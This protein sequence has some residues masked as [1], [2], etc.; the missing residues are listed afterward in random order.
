[1]GLS[2]D[3]SLTLAALE[4]IDQICQTFEL[5]WQ[6]GQAPRIEAYLGDVR[7]SERLSL[8]YQLLLLEL[9]Y[10]S[11]HGDMPSLEH[12]RTRFSDHSALIDT[13]FDKQFVL[14]TNSAKASELEEQHVHEK[15]A[16]ADN[17]DNRASPDSGL[18][19]RCPHCHKKTE[20][21]VNT[22]LAEITCSSCGCPFSLV[23][24]STGS[25]EPK[26]LKAL[27]HFLLVKQL[28]T[29]A[30][31]S[32]WKAHDTKLDRDVAV[33][34]PRRD[35]LSLVEKEQ[36]LREAR[37]VAQLNHPQIV[38]VHELGSE[39]GQL[40]IVSDFVEGVS[41]AEWI[42]DQRMTTR[43]AAELCAKVAD[44]LEHAHQ[45]GV[46][47]RDLKPANIMLDAEGEPHI[48]DF[49]LA[50][51]E[52]GEVT[53]TVEGKMLGT[54]AYMSP[55]QAKG[56]AHAADCR[57]DVYSLGVILFE[58]LSGERPFRGNTRML[59]HQVA[60]DEPPSPRKL[61]SIVPRDL[62]TICLKCLEKDSARRYATGQE[63]AAELKRFLRGEPIHARPIR[64]SERM[65]RWCKRKPLVAGLAALVALLLLILS[66]GGPVVAIHR[67]ALQREANDERQNALT[68]RQLVRQERDTALHNLYISKMRQAYLD[69]KGGLGRR[70]QNNLLDQIPL[71]GKRDFRSW[72]WYF[73]LSQLY[74]CP[75]TIPIHQEDLKR[76]TPVTNLRYRNPFAWSPDGRRL[77]LA[78]GN[79][80][81]KVWDASTESIEYIPRGHDG[82][83]LSVDWKPDGHQLASA[84]EDGTVRIWDSGTYQVLSTLRGHT[85]AVEVVQ[86]SPDGT[87]L[88]SAGRDLT[89]RIWDPSTGETVQ[90]LK[91]S[92]F[93]LAWS[94]DGDRLAVGGGL[95]QGLKKSDYPVPT[96]VNIWEAVTGELLHN[97]QRESPIYAVAWSPDG[98]K[99]AFCG[100]GDDAGS[101][102]LVNAHT[103]EMIR[104]MNKNEV[105]SIAWGPYGKLLATASWNKELGIWDVAS[106]QLLQA[107]KGHKGAVVRV[108][109]DPTESRIATA[110]YD[111]TVKIWNVDTKTPLQTL[112]GH[113]SSVISLQWNWNGT[114]LASASP[115][116]IRVWEMKSVP[117]ATQSLE[118]NA[119]SI[120]PFAISPNVHHVITTNNDQSLSVWAVE[121]GKQIHTI[122]MKGHAGLEKLSAN[123]RPR[124]SELVRWN[125]DTLEIAW[126]DREAAVHIWNTTTDEP[127]RSLIGHTSRLRQLAWSQDGRRL[128]SGDYEC[129]VRIWDGPSGREEHVIRVNDNPDTQVYGVESLAWSNHGRMLASGTRDGRVKIWDTST[130]EKLRSLEGHSP[131]Q[132]IW[133]VAWSPDDKRLASG[134]WDSIVRIWDVES[135]SELWSLQG[136]IAQIGSLAWTA[137]GKRLASE[138]ADETVRIWDV[139]LGREIMVLPVTS[140]CNLTFGA[141]GTRL[142]AITGLSERH[143]W[144]ASIGYLIESQADESWQ[145]AKVRHF[146][147]KYVRLKRTQQLTEAELAL[148]VALT[149]QEK[150]IVAHPN[151]PEFQ[152]KLNQLHGYAD[153]HSGQ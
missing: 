17:T 97:F 139:D 2:P 81:V 29:G 55:E 74:D 148:H 114:L 54:P 58:L 117:V 141:D 116:E 70:L 151:I 103:G 115:T 152:E 41:L 52:T 100:E 79:R 99:L 145:A 120:R 85:G 104:R 39:D 7:E 118:W 8:L 22:P 142:F 4:R 35:Q 83:V 153:V 128:A 137:D 129:I 47:H 31:G 147:K 91:Q 50:K 144:D 16:V 105:F 134:G 3:P 109:W 125:P 28:G 48:M 102:N 38:S 37:A 72:E 110:S 80:T 18:P 135:G 59:I 32:V 94:P 23:H 106:G 112:R 138:S 127:V 44:A 69:L 132:G 75:L 51:R 49:G 43:E 149:E 122:S 36:F 25:H 10:L 113:V 126:A 34:I 98:E 14:S 67:A 20:I 26:D 86:W 66:I 27:S 119:S 89:V 77:A 121:T 12:Y 62:E 5:A 87:A 96:G 124:E 146:Y 33:K 130:G 133:T 150:L 65:W 13:A 123:Q 42:S 88:A 30:Y 68:S 60:N 45:A 11:H 84:S 82:N 101:V 15:N 76:L 108:G 57:S 9:D 19:I 93:P 1:M 53:M 107:R 6:N 136:H 63:L 21:V 40:Y 90:L 140:R 56:E 143:V 95:P 61:N 73:L 64:R 78:C 111:E 71:E 24:E 46:I 131:N 92:W